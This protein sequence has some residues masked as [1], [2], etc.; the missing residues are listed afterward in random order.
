MGGEKISDWF[1]AN[2]AG[3]RIGILLN[4]NG[5][6]AK[7]PV[8]DGELRKKYVELSMLILEIIKAEGEKLGRL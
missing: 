4:V 6:L 3:R 8:T 5:A 1:A 7:Y 2:D